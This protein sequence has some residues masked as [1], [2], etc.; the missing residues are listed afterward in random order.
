MKKL[1]MV[2]LCCVIGAG[3]VFASGQAEAKAKAEM[4]KIGAS[5]ADFNLEKWPREAKL[6]AEAAQKYGAELIVQVANHDVKLQNDQIENL[7]LQGCDVII[8]VAEDADAAVT[9]VE[10]AAASG[11]PVIAYDRMIY[12]DKLSAYVTGDPKENG[13]NQAR[14]VLNILDKGRFVLLGGSP[15]DNNAY[16][17]REGQLEILQPYIDK[18]QIEVVADQWVDNW[19]PAIATQKMENILT[20]LANNIDAVVAMNDGTALGAIQALRAQGLNGKVPISGLDATLAGC[21]A[22]VEGDLTC[23]LYRDPKDRVYAAVEVAVNL[24]KGKGPVAEPKST[25]RILK[26]VPLSEIVAD[27]TVA[28]RLKGSITYVQSGNILVTKE[29]LYDTVIKSGF[30]KW[31]DVYKDIPEDKRPPKP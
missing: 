12:T 20:A 18:K 9:A 26:N 16:K 5:F 10:Q 6:M 2:L 13:R 4:L 21:K 14:A 25:L 22:I 28:S 23:T 30:Q 31:E 19:D 17:M 15:T 8:V 1:L 27:A 29:N 24:A 3:A 11:I 7:A